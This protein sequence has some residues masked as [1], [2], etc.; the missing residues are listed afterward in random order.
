MRSDCQN[1]HNRF[2][3]TAESVLCPQ[4]QRIEEYLSVLPPGKHRKVDDLLIELLKLTLPD[5][6]ESTIF[7]F[8][9]S[10]LGRKLFL[11]N[12]R[13]HALKE[14]QLD[15]HDF[16]SC[17]VQFLLS[18]LP[19]K[20]ACYLKNSNPPA[21]LFSQDLFK[22]NDSIP[23][24]IVTE[25]DLA[26]HLCQAMLELKIDI[27]ERKFTSPG[28]GNQQTKLLVKKT[29][30][31]LNKTITADKDLNPELPEGIQEIVLNSTF[32]SWF[33]KQIITLPAYKTLPVE[34]K[35]SL[36][37][38]L[39]YQALK[40]DV[41]P[42]C[43]EK[44]AIEIKAIRKT[45]TPEKPSHLKAANTLA[46]S[47]LVIALKD[48]I[49]RT[50]ILKLYSHISSLIFRS[51]T[52]YPLGHLKTISNVM[53]KI[54][55]A[56]K[57]ENRREI[58]RL[59]KKLVHLV[60]TEPLFLS[61]SGRFLLQR[62]Q[63]PRFNLPDLPTPGN[64][65]SISFKAALWEE[66]EPEWECLRE[67]AA[68]DL[69]VLKA[70]IL[71]GLGEDPEICRLMIAHPEFAIDY[72]CYEEKNSPLVTKLEPLSKGPFLPSTS[73]DRVIFNETGQITGL[74]TIRQCPQSAWSQ[75][76][77]ITRTN[78]VYL[79]RWLTLKKNQGSEDFTMI[80]RLIRLIQHI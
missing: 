33:E 20:R 12:L 54:I 63:W 74:S 17:P 6:T 66:Y 26:E 24:E 65:N 27:Y 77:Q 52:F 50:S 3:L 34:K 46:E 39:L 67:L 57:K 7:N 40:D 13:P 45:F 69:N 10:E 73:I 14:R 80:D 78:L 19:L 18:A 4:D 29:I 76:Q 28:I 60:K 68:M 35:L 11:S 79:A 53:Q 22:E 61:P 48:K 30:G 9:M 58:G 56:T 23:A 47:V 41:T 25:Q 71:M 36:F 32:Q 37:S 59:S 51:P 38:R 15:R 75:C 72:Y 70:A 44:L 64:D 1:A 42:V 21:I 8:Y 43:L 49:P 31:S 55:L 5:S 62:I 16:N 2:K